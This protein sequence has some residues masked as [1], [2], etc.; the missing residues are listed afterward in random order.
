[1][2]RKKHKSK[3]L[4]PK[5]AKTRPKPPPGKYD[6]ALDAQLGSVNRGFED[7][8][9]DFTRDYG[10][11]GHGGLAFYDYTLG[12]GD[13]LQDAE[14]AWIDIDQ[15]LGREREDY[16]RGTDNLGRR[17]QR[18]AGQQT[19][20]ANARGAI[21]GA[22]MQAARKRAANQSLDQGE[23]DLSHQRRFGDLVKDRTRLFGDVDRF[24]D[25][26]GVGGDVGRNLGRH[27]LGYQR[28]STD[29]LTGLERGRREQTQFGID[30]EKAK[31]FQARQAGWT[32]RRRPAIASQKTTSRRRRRGR[33]PVASVNTPSY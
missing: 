27:A 8:L 11:E 20:A 22:L 29:A 2:A 17:Y 28:Q 7:L 30:T 15:A 24:G 31:I 16:N 9:A 1:M 4:G 33:G 13:I 23:L 32:P 19:Q 3:T 12:R 21:G 6:P 10:A 14:R 26:S 25:G 18:L 5:L